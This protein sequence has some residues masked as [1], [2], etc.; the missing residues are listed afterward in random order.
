[1]GRTVTR[2]GHSA[3]QLV[4]VVPNRSRADG[5]N[6]QNRDVDFGVTP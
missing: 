5:R 1:M 4:L 2:S 6:G 3:H